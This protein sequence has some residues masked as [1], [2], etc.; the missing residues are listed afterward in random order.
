MQQD[1]LQWRSVRLAKTTR[2]M[3]GTCLLISEPLLWQIT[4]AGFGDMEIGADAA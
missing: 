2:I 1:V 4:G 3:L